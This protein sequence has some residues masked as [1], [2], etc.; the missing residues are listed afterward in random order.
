MRRS[1]FSW[2]QLALLAAFLLVALNTCSSQQAEGVEVS[3]E[4]EDCAELA[5]EVDACLDGWTSRG[6]LILGADGVPIGIARI[7]PDYILVDWYAWVDGRP[8]D[9][10]IW[11]GDAGEVMVW[12]NDHYIGERFLSAHRGRLRV[13]VP[14][15][16]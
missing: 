3:S 4:L 5:T 2:A 12:L 13:S 1:T 8:L 7:P 6:W 14:L 16:I 11:R 15:D 9:I 10:H